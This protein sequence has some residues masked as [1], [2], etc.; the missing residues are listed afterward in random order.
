MTWPLGSPSSR[1]RSRRLG[2]SS[3]MILVMVPLYRTSAGVP[4][5]CGG[6][7][8]LQALAR[9]CTHPP[10][11]PDMTR[12]CARVP[13]KST[14]AHMCISLHTCS[15][16]CGFKREGRGTSLV[17]QR[18]GLHAFTAGT[19]VQFLVEDLRS[20]KLPCGPGKKEK[21]GEAEPS[22]TQPHGTDISDVNN[23]L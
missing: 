18:L 10:N 8:H 5:G 21:M 6:G 9:D 11:S 1:L 20:C 3:P 16:T 22:R 13:S 23:K 4:W 14:R 7:Y 12:T 19:Q 17:V 2:L 15:Y